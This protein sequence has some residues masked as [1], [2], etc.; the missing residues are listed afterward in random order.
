MSCCISSREVFEGE[1]AEE[2]GA[3][4][5]SRCFLANKK[6]K[7]FVDGNFHNF[8]EFIAYTNNQKR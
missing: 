4:G 6:L 2:G 3:C 7:S 1:S 8:F 5:G